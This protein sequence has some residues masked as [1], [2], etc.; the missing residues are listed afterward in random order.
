MEMVA[1]GVETA[2]QAALLR[3]L[4]CD[5]LQGYHFG[6]PMAVDGMTTLLRRGTGA[7][8]TAGEPGAG[9]PSGG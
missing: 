3:T 7:P 8:G 1:E 2:E 5:L 4:E 6:M 9:A